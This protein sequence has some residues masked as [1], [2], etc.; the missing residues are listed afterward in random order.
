MKFRNLLVPLLALVI[1]L[2]AC[3]TKS[4][5]APEQATIY[6]SFYPIYDFTSRIVGDTAEIVNLM[7]AGAS[8]HDYEPTARDLVSLR[9]ADVLVYLGAGMEEWFDKV[10]TALAQDGSEIKLIEAAHGMELLSG[11]EHEED[12]HDHDHEEDEGHD[13]D[14]EEDDHGHSH[15][16]CDPHI[17][18]SPVK[19]IELLKTIQT[20]LAEIFPE[21]RELYQENYQKA[22]A[23]F[24]ALD[25]EFRT[26]LSGS[27]IKHFLVTHEAFGYLADAYGLE[28]HGISGMG[29]EQE[30]SPEKMRQLIEFARSEEIDHVYFEASGSDKVARA[31]A[32]EIDGKVLPLETLSN[33]GEDQLAGG[34]DYLA[35]MRENLKNLLESAE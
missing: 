23:E 32:E 31:L 20:E 5:Q 28:Q 15:G 2:A 34:K 30:P 3:D 13:H 29:T 27:G 33:P 10:S 9:D 1:G 6:T 4:P 25:E 12:E 24:R 18:L 7:P 17:W 19:A 11:H 8:Q 16:R 35:L 22:E 21:H 26:K 14:H